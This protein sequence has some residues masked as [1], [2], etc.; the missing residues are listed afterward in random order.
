[1][2]DMQIGGILQDVSN[3]RAPFHH[4]AEID[5]SCAADDVG[6][7]RGLARRALNVCH[8]V[9]A[10]GNHITLVQTDVCPAVRPVP[11]D[12]TALAIALRRADKALQDNPAASGE[13]QTD[14]ESDV[15]NQLRQFH[16]WNAVR[17]HI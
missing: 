10:D 11:H 8:V 13:V 14:N 16:I 7:F 2:S 9:A 15:G 6:G 1:M 4:V 3:R 12:D 17:K 5:G